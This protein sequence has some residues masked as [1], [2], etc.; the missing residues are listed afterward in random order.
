MLRIPK[1]GTRFPKFVIRLSNLARE[2]R[3]AKGTSKF[4]IL[5][6]LF[7][8]KFL[9]EIAAREAGTSNRRH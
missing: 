4:L 6:P 5:V 8:L 7:D 3:K 1:P 9:I 2:F